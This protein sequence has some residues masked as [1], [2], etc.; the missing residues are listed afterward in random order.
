MYN[1]CIVKN[2]DNINH[3]ILGVEL[4]PNGEYQIPDNKRV[5]ASNSDDLLNGIVSNIFQIG[6]GSSFF[7][8][9]GSQINYLKSGI[10]NVSVDSINTTITTKDSAEGFKLDRSNNDI[11]L[12]STYDNFLNI[13]NS[14]EFF[15]MKMVFSND[16]LDIKLIIDGVTVFE[17]PLEEIKDMNYKK[18]TN[19]GLNRF[20]GGSQFGEF[21]FFPIKPL[22]YNTSLVIQVKKTVNWNI[23]N[24]YYHFFYSED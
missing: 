14:G 2:I 20:F 9:V 3:I 24:E 16:E 15:G 7:E 12:T 13:T 21:E 22:K 8:T 6:N 18:D 17:I 5:M 10:K 4:P 11:T 19:V 23:K 1:T